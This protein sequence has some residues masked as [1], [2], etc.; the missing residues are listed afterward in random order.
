MDDPF[1]DLHVEWRVSLERGHLVDLNQVRLQLVVYHHIE[2]KNLEAHAVLNV[3]ELSI[4]IK[5][6]HVR[7]WNTDRL[8]D[9]FFDLLN[10]VI[11]MIFDEVLGNEVK[12]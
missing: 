2:P 1:L 8:K 3:I 9:D 7:L 4:P 11:D 12:H 5:V 10:H 6:K